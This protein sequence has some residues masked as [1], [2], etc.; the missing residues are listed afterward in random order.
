MVPVVLYL[1]ERLIRALRSGI[2]AVS[3]LKV[4]FIN[5]SLLKYPHTKRKRGFCIF[6][7]IITLI[8]QQVAVLPGNVLSLQMSRPNNFRY[9]SGQY[10]YLNCSEVSSLEW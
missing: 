5:I 2:E 9:K 3:I 1:F 10:M 4:G 6:I 7:S 8:L